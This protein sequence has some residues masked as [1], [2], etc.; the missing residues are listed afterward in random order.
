MNCMFCGLPEPKH[1]GPKQWC[2]KGQIQ[3]QPLKAFTPKRTVFPVGLV[4]MQ[5]CVHITIQRCIESL[6]QST[7]LDQFDRICLAAMKH[8][9]AQSMQ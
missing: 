6:E 3:G 9:L 8:Q 1:L 7:P 5:D 2:P 4:T